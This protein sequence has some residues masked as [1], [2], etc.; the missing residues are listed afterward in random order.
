MRGRLLSLSR[1][2]SVH[3]AALND[4]C[5]ELLNIARL[6]EQLKEPVELELVDVNAF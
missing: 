1:P 6:C 2:V 3:D 4:C 5:L